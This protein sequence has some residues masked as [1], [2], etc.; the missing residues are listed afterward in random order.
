MVADR[1]SR[2]DRRRW[3]PACA[4]A[5]RT[6][7]DHGFRAQCIARVDRDGVARR[8]RDR[9]RPWCSATAQPALSAVLW[10]TRADVAGRATAGGCRCGQRRAAR[11]RAGA[12]L[13][14]A[15]AA[16]QR[17]ERHGHAKR[18]SAAGDDLR[19]HASAW[20]RRRPV[21][22]TVHGAFMSFYA[23]LL[24]QTARAAQRCC[25]RPSSRAACAARFRCRAIS[26][27][28][29]RPITTCVTRCRCCTLAVL[30]A[31][32]Q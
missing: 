18:T 27:S 29:A 1:R 10:P 28:W 14:A 4:A 24:E 31:R 12:A 30:A 22:R 7:V 11:L 23:R 9:R 6:R 15:A 16:F 21:H 3:L 19:T 5:A 32:A 17:R 8:A 25:A 26:R 13:D 20:L 2:H